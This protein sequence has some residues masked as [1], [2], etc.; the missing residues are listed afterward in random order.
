MPGIIGQRGIGQRSG[1]IGPT[2]EEQPAFSTSLGSDQTPTADGDT[3]NF[4]TETFDIGSNFD[5]SAKT[6]TAPVAGKYFFNV[7]VRM[8]DVD[9]N[10]TFIYISLVTTGGTFASIFG[11]SGAAGGDFPNWH[12]NLPVIASMAASN[13]AKVKYNFSGGNTVGSFVG[14][15]FGSEFSGYLL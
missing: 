3:I 4:D 2:A 14:G 15:V 6:F 13:T 10:S 8:T 7:R 12:V 1:V 9:N 11:L 5:T